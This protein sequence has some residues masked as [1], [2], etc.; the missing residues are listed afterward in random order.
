VL[1]LAIVIP[2]ARSGYQAPHA[3]LA[4]ATSVA[5]YVNAGLLLRTLR[6]DGVYQPLAGWAVLG[7]RIAVAATAMGGFLL[8]G[9]GPFVNWLNASVTT[10]VVHLGWLIAGAVAVYF[11]L[12][13]LLGERPRLRTPAARE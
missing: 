11:A 12:L 13:W 1:N 2:L 6:R 3:G 5:A 9:V 4:L 10:R 8:W 7:L